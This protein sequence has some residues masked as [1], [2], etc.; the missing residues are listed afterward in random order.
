MSVAA[1]CAAVVAWSKPAAAYHTEKDRLTYGS[2]YTLGKDTIAL[3]LY[4]AQYGAFRHFD[5]GTYILP[6]FLR[7]ANFGVKWQIPVTDTID[8]A[9]QLYSF[10]LDVQKLNPD[11]PPLVIVAVPFDVTGSWRINDK[12]TL[13]LSA[14]YTWNHLEGTFDQEALKGAAAV[15]NF[16]LV[17]TWEFRWTK[18][19]ALLL[20]LRYLAYQWQPT[21]SAS[22]VLHPD[23]YTTVEV[24]GDARFDALDVRNAWSLI[25]GVAWS[26]ETFNLRVGLGYGNYN[27]PGVNF[28]LPRKTLCPELDLFWRW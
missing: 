24:Y 28:V 17:S 13:S 21:A 12:H 9:P 23:E 7:V 8:I 22:Y 18:V 2:A 25:P 11:S 4:T 27:V 5:L 1:C 20:R 19:T 16:Q 3:G 15:S 6:W 26:W 14:V 10:R